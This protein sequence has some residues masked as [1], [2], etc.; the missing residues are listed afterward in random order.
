MQISRLL[1]H[2]AATLEV[3]KCIDVREAYLVQLRELC[4]MLDG[5]REGTV[6]ASSVG[7]QIGQLVRQ[8]RWI[9]VEAVEAILSWRVR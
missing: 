4:D 1:D 9:S 8:L 3:L 2:R 5:A 6:D 7:A